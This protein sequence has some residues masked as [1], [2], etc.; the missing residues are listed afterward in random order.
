MARNG[1]TIV[2]TGKGGCSRS[3]EC[4]LTRFF[5][6]IFVDV[7]GGSDLQRELDRKAMEECTFQPKITDVAATAMTP[8]ER[9][10]LS[11]AVTNRFCAWWKWRGGGV[12]WFWF[13]YANHSKPRC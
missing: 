2:L 5:I 3:R 7:C 6:I 10:V 8:A 1:D 11:P 13:D 9:K 12:A 4:H